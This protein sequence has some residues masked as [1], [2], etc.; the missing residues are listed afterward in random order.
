MGEGV[1]GG[2]WGWLGGTRGRAGGGGAA[3]AGGAEWA[4][5]VCLEVGRRGAARDWIQN[6]CE[7][8]IGPN[9]GILRLCTTDKH[10]IG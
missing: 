6:V 2:G 4:L 3:R 5:F 9:R 10:L 7:Q 1:V 8:P